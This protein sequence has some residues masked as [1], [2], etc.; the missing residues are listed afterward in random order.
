MLFCKKCEKESF[1]NVQY[2]VLKR[3]ADAFEANGNQAPLATVDSPLYDDD[4]ISRETSVQQ[5]VMC[6]FQRCFQISKKNE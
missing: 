2:Q 6:M 1:K 3:E 5:A 4:P